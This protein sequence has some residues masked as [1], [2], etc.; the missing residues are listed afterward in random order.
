MAV[1]GWDLV[2]QPLRDDGVGQ[3]GEAAAPLGVSAERCA[4]TG[5]ESTYIESFRLLQTG[6]R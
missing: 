6:E 4:V 2:E 3:A 5:D 1:I